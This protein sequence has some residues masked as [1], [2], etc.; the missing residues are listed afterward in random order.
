M[1]SGIRISVCN[2]YRKSLDYSF[3][4]FF[5]LL[6]GADQSRFAGTGLHLPDRYLCIC[7]FYDSADSGMDTIYV[8]A[9][10]QNE[11]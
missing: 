11:E 5:Q 3:Q 10:I 7:L 4:S 9:H 1:S 2:G 6:D 8:V